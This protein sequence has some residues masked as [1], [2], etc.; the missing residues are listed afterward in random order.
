MKKFFFNIFLYLMFFTYLTFGQN[1]ITLQKQNGTILIYSTLDTILKFADN[2]DFIYFSG[3]TYNVEGINIEKKLSIFGCG[4]YPDSSDATGKTIFNGNLTIT[5]GSNGGILEG[6]FFNNGITFSGSINTFFIQR[7]YLNYLKVS[8]SSSVEEINII[9]NIIESFF[10]EYYNSSIK[11]CK[12]K[13]NIFI[14]GTIGG[15]CIIDYAY[16][17]NNIFLTT[18]NSSFYTSN[19]TFKNNIFYQCQPGN[20]GDKNILENNLFTIDSSIFFGW[21]KYSKIHDNK[22]LKST[23]KD[24]IFINHKGNNF[25]YDNNYHL[26]QKIRDLISDKQDKTEIGIYGTEDPYKEGAVPLNPHIQ[27]I[28][29]A[30]TSRPNGKLE[31]K[32]KVQAQDK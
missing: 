21:D 22:F 14:G 12:F 32:F 27:Y 8:Y 2:N 15:S 10:C 7:C 24:S 1:V 20:G 5:T 11:N 29:I 3:G 4:H 6:I 26:S 16:I 9:E 28:H 25:S 23:E 13:K 17:S 31:V 18:N 30:P 19:S